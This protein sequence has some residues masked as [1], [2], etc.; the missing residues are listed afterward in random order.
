MEVLGILSDDVETDSV[1]PGE[2]LKIRLKGIEEEEILPGFI[3][4]DL[5]NLCHSGRT[6][7]AQVNKSPHS[8]SWL[9]ETKWL[10]FQ[11]LCPEYLCMTCRM[12]SIRG[13]EV[14][15][16]ICTS[17]LYYLTISRCYKN[18]LGGI[19]VNSILFFGLLLKFRVLLTL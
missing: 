17:K 1:A 8:S 13:I 18:L 6:F 4:C 10:E 9:L 7:D 12:T 5:N 3:L 19:F 11:C 14:V 2:N 15:K 16:L